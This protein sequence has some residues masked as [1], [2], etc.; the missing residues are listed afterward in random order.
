MANIYCREID[1]RVK[2]SDKSQTFKNKFLQSECDMAKLI[3]SKNFSNYSAWHYR[4]KL[5]PIIKSD[6]DNPYALPLNVIKEDFS[7]LKHAY[8]TD[9]KDQSPWNYHAWLMSLISPIQVVAIRYLPESAE[10][11]VGFVFGLSH[12]VKDFA[13]LDISF[14]DRE[15]NPIEYEVCSA[16]SQRRDL[17]NSW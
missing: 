13:K 4:G 6:P 15:G 5:M 16:V 7:S 3:I 10:G 14:V 11:K 8:F 9:P 2:D 12:Q 1:A 17:S